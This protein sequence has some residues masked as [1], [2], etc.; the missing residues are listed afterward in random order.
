MQRFLSIFQ[1]P[2][3]KQKN[4]TQ[5]EHPIAP[6]IQVLFYRTLR[7]TAMVE[8]ETHSTSTDDSRFVYLSDLQDA[9][10]LSKS[11]VPRFRD[12]VDYWD[13]FMKDE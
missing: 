1:L 2:A 9:L 8:L 6:Q 13:A 12:G 7:C 4:I 3:A 10:R 11:K 5:K